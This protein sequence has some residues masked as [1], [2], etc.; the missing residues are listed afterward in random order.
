M[1]N[2]IIPTLTPLITV[3]EARKLLGSDCKHMCDDQV[4]EVIITLTL[5]ARKYL[6]SNSS[7]KAFGNDTIE[8]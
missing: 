8:P 7:N 2:S 3:A 1:Q 6:K 5:M 4:Q